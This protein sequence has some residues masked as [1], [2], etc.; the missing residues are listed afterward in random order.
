MRGGAP[1]LFD[2]ITA[3]QHFDWQLVPGKADDSAQIVCPLDHHS[4]LQLPL[5]RL[6]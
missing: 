1:P 5:A 4:A 2:R 6:G 3:L